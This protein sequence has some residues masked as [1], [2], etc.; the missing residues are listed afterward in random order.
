MKDLPKRIRTYYDSHPLAVILIVAALLR[1]VSVIFSRGYGMHDDHFCVI[2][3]AQRWLDGYGDWFGQSDSLRSIIYPGLHYLLFGF[4]ERIGIFNPQVKMGIVR[5]LHGAYSLLIVY[6]GYRITLKIS[7]RR[8]AALAG[9]MCAA[10][11]LMPFMS[12]RNLIEFVC[13]VPLMAGTWVLYR[14][15]RGGNL[16]TFIAGLLFGVAFVFRFQAAIFAVTVTL[17]L[18][19]GRHWRRGI[20]FSAGALAAA[21]LIQGVS[22]WFAYGFAFSSLIEYIRYNSTSAGAYVVGSWHQY[23]SLLLGIFIPPVSI[24]IMYGWIAGWKKH[25]LIFWPSLVY[26]VL[27]S[28]YPGKQERFILPVVPFIIIGGIAGWRASKL[29]ERLMRMRPGLLHGF[30]VWFWVINGILLAISMPTYVKKARCETLSRI[31]HDHDAQAIVLEGNTSP[32]PKFYVDTKIP[33]YY[34]DNP[35]D[36]ETAKAAMD[37][38]GVVPNY[39]ICVGEDNLEARLDRLGGLFSDIAL[40]SRVTPGILD[41]L[42]HAINPKFNKNFASTVY[43]VRYP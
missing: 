35:D 13:I 18:V 40:E 30:W 22:D 39:L 27:H 38:A 9:W 24:M 32:A 5:F 21:F 12:V 2:E 8:S 34:I 37:S 20:M 14:D 28:L 19:I 6:F 4:L 23:I 33:V 3:V 26:F 16:S 29:C 42:L 11:W 31:W 15:D 17:L 43:K 10:F 7:D 25:A 36:I 1:L 41:A